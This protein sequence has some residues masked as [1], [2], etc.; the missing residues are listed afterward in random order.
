MLFALRAPGSGLRQW[1]AITRKAL[2][3]RKE[4]IGLCYPTLTLEQIHAT[5]TYYLAHSDRVVA[6]LKRV[7]QQ[8]EAAYQQSQQHSSELIRSLRERVARLRQ[9]DRF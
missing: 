7:R 3:P 9:S 4:E 5:I 8:Q 6:Y 1:C 2:A